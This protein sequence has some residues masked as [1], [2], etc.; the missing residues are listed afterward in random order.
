MGLPITK[1]RDPHHGHSAD[2]EFHPQ[3]KDKGVMKFGKAAGEKCK[4]TTEEDAKDCIRKY[5]EFYSGDWSYPFN[6]CHTFMNRIMKYCC[7]ER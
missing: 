4:C 3:R 2:E 5:A 1:D 7:L 6:S